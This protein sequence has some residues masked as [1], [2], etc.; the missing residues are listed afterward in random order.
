[1]LSSHSIKNKEFMSAKANTMYK[2]VPINYFGTST[3]SKKGLWSLFSLS[4]SIETSLS[5]FSGTSSSCVG[6]S[7]SCVGSSSSC[8][9]SSSSRVGSSSSCVGTSSS[10][11]GSSSSCAGTSSSFIQN[12]QLI[13]FTASMNKIN[14]HN[15]LLKIKMVKS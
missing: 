5:S 11:V 7:S 9:G 15:I 8:V 10:C 14:D 1:M 6:S 12:H 3:P 4:C 2:S 13:A